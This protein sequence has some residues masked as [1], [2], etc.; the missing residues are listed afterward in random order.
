M[1]WRW[2]FPPDAPGDGA[3]QDRVAVFTVVD[4][5]AGLL[6]GPVPD[7]VRDPAGRCSVDPGSNGSRSGP[8]R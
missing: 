5:P 1:S 2:P 3:A 4:V 7:A 6:D 8:M